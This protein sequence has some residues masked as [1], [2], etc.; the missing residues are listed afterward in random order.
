[1]LLLVDPPVLMNDFDDSR[2]ES[3]LFE[4]GYIRTRDSNNV[5]KFKKSK[6]KIDN[7]CWT[8][9]LWEGLEMKA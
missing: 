4:K 3:S 6:V 7:I 9:N 2:P 1:M 8:L 5:Y